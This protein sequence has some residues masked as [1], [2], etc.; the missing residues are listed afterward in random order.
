M[1]QVTFRGDMFT[2]DIVFTCNFVPRLDDR[3]T[4]SSDGG[5]NTT[6][7]IVSDVDWIF[8]DSGQHAIVLL[9]SSM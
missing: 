2:G 1:I 3:V 7:G 6:S 4:I 8:D 9:K 5:M